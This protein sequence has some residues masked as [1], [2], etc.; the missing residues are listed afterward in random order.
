MDAVMNH[1]IL[2]RYLCNSGDPLMCN[3]LPKLIAQRAKRVSRVVAF[4]CFQCA[5]KDLAADLNV[6]IYLHQHLHLYLPSFSGSLPR[7]TDPT[8]AE[9]KET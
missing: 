8:E 5:C 9:F 1:W 7:A 6:D 3:R 2:D 4:N